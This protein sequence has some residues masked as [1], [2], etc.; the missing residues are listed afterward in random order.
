MAVDKE[1]KSFK[2]HIS[3][4]SDN[5][6]CFE[7]AANARGGFKRGGDVTPVKMVHAYVRGQG[8]LE[9]RRFSHGFNLLTDDVVQD[10]SNGNEIVMRRE[11]YY[12]IGGINPKEKGAYKEYTKKETM[13]ALVKHGHY[14]PWDLN[15]ALDEEIPNQKKEIGKKKLKIPAKVLRK[16]KEELE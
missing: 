7:V 5:G 3:E 9:G 12:E 8:A 16:A 4:A 2:Q 1:M 10:N 11:Q 6:D 15:K 14:G 13:A